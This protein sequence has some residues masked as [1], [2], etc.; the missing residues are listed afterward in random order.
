MTHSARKKLAIESVRRGRYQTVVLGGP[1]FFQVVEVVFPEAA[2]GIAMSIAAT[3][4]TTR[5][6]NGPS[7][8]QEAEGS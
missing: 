4:T 8:S 5:R 3:K 1:M 6:F 7:V 2:A